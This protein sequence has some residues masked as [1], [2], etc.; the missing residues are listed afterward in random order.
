MNIILICLTFLFALLF[1]INYLKP[2]KS[3]IVKTIS[4]L[5]VGAVF[6]FSGFVKAVDPMGSTIKYT[7]YF[8]SFGLEYLINF[9]FPLAII[10][11]TIEFMVGLSLILN[12][13][14]KINSTIVLL[15]MAF[16]TPLT[17]YLAIANPVTDCGCFGDALVITNWQTFW[18]N[19]VILMPTLIL[20]FNRNDIK[21]WLSKTNELLVSLIGMVGIISDHT[22]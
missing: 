1:L 19:I 22:R 13:K 9:V 8:H 5:F 10:L 11:S 4:R 2:D 15:F 20:F 14:I 16:F 18:K 6:V 17:F 12:I 3:L 21:A 7:D